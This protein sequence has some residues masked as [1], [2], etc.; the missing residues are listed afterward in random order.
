MKH[1]TVRISAGTHEKLVEYAN[2]NAMKIGMLVDKAVL[3]KIDKNYVI[4]GDVQIDGKDLKIVID[5]AQKGR[6][7]NG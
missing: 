4:S 1:Q 6:N 2:K 7:R 3:E 5:R